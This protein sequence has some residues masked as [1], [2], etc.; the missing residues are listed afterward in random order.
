VR[1]PVAV[2]VI[3]ACLAA[4]RPARGEVELTSDLSLGGGALVAGEEPSG[5]LF[6][7]GA[8]AEATFLRRSNRDLGLGIYVE[9]MTST[10]LDVMGSVGATLLIPVHHGLPIVL[11]VGPHYTYSGRH[12]GGVGGRLWWGFHNHN[13]THFYNGTFGLWL[14]VRGDLT[15]ERD[16][17]LAAGVDIDLS[18]FVYPFVFID[19]WARGPERP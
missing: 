12:D 10:F 13:L 2:A 14:E 16:V 5:G 6:R 9:V 8:H 11:F 4:V 3:L 1:S 19:R 17:L 18:L 7:F 15:G